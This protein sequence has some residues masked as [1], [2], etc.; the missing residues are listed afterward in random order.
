MR[1]QKTIIKCFFSFIMTLAFLAVTVV[2]FKDLTG[3]FL[4]SLCSF[5]WIVYWDIAFYDRK[6]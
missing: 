6:E 2:G 1:F 4:F 5:L 3:E